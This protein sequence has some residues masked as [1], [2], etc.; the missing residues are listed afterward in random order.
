MSHAS[1]PSFSLDA[2]VD[3]LW[4]AF[5]PIAV[6]LRDVIMSQSASSTTS[7]PQA[8]GTAS[9]PPVI[10][11]LQN[12]RAACTHLT[13]E[14]LYGDYECM[15]CHRT[16]SWGWVYV[17]T[18]DGRDE[19][20]ES[21]RTSFS[22]GP[23]WTAELSPWIQ[24]A[25]LDG[26]YTAEQIDKMVCQ[27]KKVLDTIAASEAH[28]KKTQPASSRTSIRK[29][30]SA[31]STP[32]TATS[33]FVDTNPQLPF[34][35]ITDLAGSNL[36]K[37]RDSVIST[38]STKSRIFPIC[39]YRACQLCR[40]TYRDRSWQV[41][42]NAFASRIT[43]PSIA[44]G[45]PD[46]PTANASLLKGMGIRTPAKPKRPALSRKYDTVGVYEADDEQQ[47]KGKRKH[48]STKRSAS[49]GRDREVDVTDQRPE[50][51]TQGFRNSAKR[52][53]KGMLMT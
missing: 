20:V 53:I 13:M 42:E 50:T 32:A 18:Q 36:T 48:S 23:A 25:I 19:E 45:A 10:P 4:D 51:D 22:A 34:P 38:T 11:T 12:R 41:F 35:L 1:T 29:S 47:K 15:A 7:M 17:C 28:F 37:P 24:N 39:R 26:H 2:S 16:S 46:K 43:P 6:T 31:P 44:E 30:L 40:P 21:S 8:D 3:A 52:A 14:R 9:P 27:R 5:R 49:A 33:T